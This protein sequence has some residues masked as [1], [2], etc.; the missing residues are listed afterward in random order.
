MNR[1]KPTALDPVRV[2]VIDDSSVVR[3][4]LTKDLGSYPQIRVVGSAP[5]PFVARALIDKLDPEVLVLDLELPRMDGLTFLRR[6]MQH[7]PTPTIVVSSL[8]PK[9]ATLASACLAAGAIDVLSKPNG[10]YSISDLSREL[11]DIVLGARFVNMQRLGGMCDTPAVPLKSGA[12]LSS[13]DKV[14]AIGASTGGTA[15]LVEVLSPLPERMHGVV[16]VQH[17]P[18]HFTTRFA[19]RLN[20]L[21]QL[22]VRE[23]QDGDIVAR[24]VA[25]LAPGGMQMRL[26]RTGDAYRVRVAP[27]PPVMRHCPSVEVLF[28][29]VSRTAG[30]NA[31]G[32]ILTGMGNDGAAALRAMHNEGALTIAQDEASCVVFGMPK[33]AIAAGGVDEVLSLDRIAGR[34]VDYAAGRARGSSKLAG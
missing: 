12:A 29:S 34:V 19:E 21:C 22:E 1:A 10:S 28:E 32:I 8:T 3:A 15:A 27:G 18:A 6:I 17:M 33:E 13:T 14:I 20:G 9:G 26:V 24:G 25:L 16:I 11:A 7:R 5:D 30:A 4:R 31:L 23:A 2:L